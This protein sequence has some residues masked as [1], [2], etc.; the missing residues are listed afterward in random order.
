[1]PISKALYHMALVEIQ[2]LKKQFQELLDSDFIWPNCSPWGILIFFVK[3]KDGSIHMC[4]DYREL[5]KVIINKKYP[6]SRINDLFDQLNGVSM[7]LNIN[8]RSKYH[9]VWVV[10]RDIIMIAFRITY[11]HYKFVVILFRLTNAPIVIID[12][13][14]RIFQVCLNK[15]L[16]VFIDDILVYSRTR[17][18]HKQHLRFML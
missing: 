17:E 16:V 6:L 10:D 2:E 7:F 15:F 14:N 5:N 4:I 11:G 8:L 18:K 12:L 3:R 9:Q 13:I 1:M